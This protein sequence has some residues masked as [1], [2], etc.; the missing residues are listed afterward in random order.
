MRWVQQMNTY[1]NVDATIYGF[2]LSGT[3]IATA[4]LA[5]DYG[6]AYQRGEKDTP[7]F[8]GKQEQICLKSLHSSLMLP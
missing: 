8:K 7:L 6:M 5:F 1:E 4:E 3:Y 2:E